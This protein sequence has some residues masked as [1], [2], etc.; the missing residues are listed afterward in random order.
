MPIDALPRLTVYSRRDCHLCE[1]MIAALR[2]LEGGFG[3]EIAVTDVDSDAELARRYGESIPVLAH[4]ERELCHFRLD[5]E[6]V[7]AYLSK[8]R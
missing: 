6:L 5:R 3:F 8:I 2:Q 4:G 7:T 1:E